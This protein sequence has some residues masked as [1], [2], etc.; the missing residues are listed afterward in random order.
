M[1]VI[2]S[3]N[4]MSSPFAGPW[5]IL[6]TLLFELCM[7]LWVGVSSSSDGGGGSSSNSSDSD[8]NG[9]SNFFV[10]VEIGTY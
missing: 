6:G 8:S 4:L 3:S 9:D 7:Y 1:I 10:V 2:V 5:L